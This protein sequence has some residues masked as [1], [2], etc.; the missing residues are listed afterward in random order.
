[1]EVLQ[2]IKNLDEFFN[3]I[4]RIKKND[5]RGIEGREE[6]LDAVIRACIETRRYTS[7]L[8]EGNDISSTGLHGGD[9]SELWLS[10]STKMARFD[11]T[12][13][14]EYVIKAYGWST[15][16]WDH[17]DFK[18]VPRKVEAILAEALELRK[19]FQPILTNKVI[20]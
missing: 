6:V 1:M 10:A 4:S 11:P 8:S 14:N 19:S 3:I 20:H 17:P 9:I 16:H 13:A 15:G 18:E 5:I 2:A 7:A 12:V